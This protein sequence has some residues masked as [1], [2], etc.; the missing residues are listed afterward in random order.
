MVDQ[1]V[2]AVRAESL[3]RHDRSRSETWG[4]DGTFPALK[5]KSPTAQEIAH[6]AAS[7]RPISQGGLLFEEQKA[8][9]LLLPIPGEECTPPD[10]DK[11]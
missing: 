9:L 1:G 5:A 7:L 3:I 10:V 4:P 6:P 11:D 8:A 2:E